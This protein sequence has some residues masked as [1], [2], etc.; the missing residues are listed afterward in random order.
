MFQA[1]AVVKDASKN[2]VGCLLEKVHTN[3]KVKHCGYS[4]LLGINLV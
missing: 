3:P 4:R 1:G 2:Y